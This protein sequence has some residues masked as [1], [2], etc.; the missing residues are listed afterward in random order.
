MSNYFLTANLFL[1]VAYLLYRLLLE[2]ETFFR[3]NRFLLPAILLG[4]ALL[5][6]VSV[7][8]P[9]EWSF[10][11]VWTGPEPAQKSGTP[12]VDPPSSGQ[13]NGAAGPAPALDVWS[14]SAR[15]Y[16][17]GIAVMSVR[18]LAQLVS[19]A[20]LLIRADRE[21]RDGYILVRARERT[22]PFSFFRYIVV[23]QTDYPPALRERIL[24]HEREHV[25]QG[26]TWDLLLAELGLIFFWCNPCAW[27]LR[28]S[29]ELNLEYLTDRA[30][31]ER[32]IDR[33][34]YQYS[35]LQ[36]V[37]PG[38]SSA[39]AISFNH[40]IVKKRIKMMNQERSPAAARRRYL[41]FLPLLL[42]FLF[43]NS[44]TAPPLPPAGDEVP[45]YILITEKATK[46]EFILL[47][48]YLLE[49][50]AQV[51]L[52]QLVY[53]GRRQITRIDLE[54]R[55]GRGRLSF[56]QEGPDGQGFGL[57]QYLRLLTPRAGTGHLG[58]AEWAEVRDQFDEVV[59]LLLDGNDSADDVRDLRLD[60]KEFEA[61]RPRVAQAE[62]TA[63]MRLREKLAAADWQLT[64]SSSAT[65]EGNAEN[66]RRVKER[67]AG[68]G[69]PV[70]YYLDGIERDAAMLDLPPGRMEEI[71][72]TE[73][74]TTTF[75]PGT[76]E[77]VDKEARMRVEVRRK[78]EE[79][80]V[81]Y[82]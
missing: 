69:A 7:Y 16:W 62:R 68:T 49:R 58:T 72:V 35:L 11:T 29:V 26:H 74:I 77:P 46:K 32:G 60:R 23:D 31:L 43:L 25:R 80:E 47:Q 22:A 51:H 45:H 6:L 64:H 4:A 2:R 82:K 55:Q 39:L 53:N 52:N 56:Q 14:W 76:L 71:R 17:F 30:V 33:K 59:V 36:A 54:A 73:E 44:T 13:E 81:K 20:R 42:G 18:L 61:L 63:E 27:L 15:L 9:A 70:T 28:R 38:F 8:L 41:A 67:L 40:S 19:L 78:A 37:R 5:P 34:A 3:A 65:Y 24:A 1:A 10:Q 48:D 50:G 79:G 75:D 66:I 21:E 12:A 57:I